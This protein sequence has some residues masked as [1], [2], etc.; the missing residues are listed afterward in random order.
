MLLEFI[1]T[2]LGAFAAGYLTVMVL[3]TLG[4]FI[5]KDL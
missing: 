3:Y 1:A 5:F 4:K 2:A